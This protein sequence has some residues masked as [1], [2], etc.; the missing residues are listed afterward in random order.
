MIIGLKFSVRKTIIHFE[1]IPQTVFIM[2]LK[3][4]I[5]AN[6]LTFLS[7]DLVRTVLQITDSFSEEKIAK[8]ES[9]SKYFN[10]SQPPNC[11]II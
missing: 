10:N 8:K 2:S 9:G 1:K 6:K 7:F 3:I 4:S 11:M 5:P